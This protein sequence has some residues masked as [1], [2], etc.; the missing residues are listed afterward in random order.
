M[1]DRVFVG[2]A[3]AMGG[4]PGGPGEGPGGA[5]FFLQLV[6]FLAVFL[7]FYFI[8]FRPQQAAARK[9]QEMLKAIKRGDAVYTSGGLH[10]KVTGITDKVVTLEIADNVRVKV[11]RSFVAGLVSPGEDARPE[12]SS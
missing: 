4:A 11:Y 2:T 7:I 10:G 5:S 9:R 6:P 8:L 12:G 3:H 1:L